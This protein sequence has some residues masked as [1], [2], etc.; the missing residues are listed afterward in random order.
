MLN[1]KLISISAMVMLLTSFFTV[2]AQ[3]TTQQPS[4]RRW[5]W[6]SGTPRFDNEAYLRKYKGMKPDTGNPWTII[7]SDDYLGVEYPQDFDLI[8]EGVH[9]RI[10]VGLND[11]ITLTNGTVVSDYQDDEGNFHFFYPWTDTGVSDPA[12][13]H[14]P[15]YHD[16]ISMERLSYMLQQFD[17]V[18]YPTDTTY[19][20]MP[21][22]RPPGNTKIDILIFNIRDE[23]FWSPE[24]APYY[25]GGYFS[26]AVSLINKRNIIHVDT[27]IGPLSYPYETVVAHEFQ[28]LIHF[29][30]DSDEEL[31]VDEGCADFAIFLCGYGHPADHI[32]YYLVYH[33]LTS[34]TFWGGGLEDY[35]ASYLFILYLSEHYGGAEMI[36]DLVE[37]SLNG[38]EG[39]ENTLA[40]HGYTI[41]FDGVF[42]NWAI[43]NYID[44][45]SIGNGEYG[46]FTLDIPS[47]DTRGLSIE[48]A[49]YNLWQVP[50]IGRGFGLSASVW[51]GFV[52]P[53]TA[54]Y[55]RFG[56][57]PAGYEANLLY[58][59]DAESGT[60]ANDWKGTVIDVTGYA[61]YRRTFTGRK[62]NFKPVM[63]YNVWHIMSGSLT[64]PKEHVNRGHLFVAIF[65]N[66]APHLLPG[67][68][69]FYAY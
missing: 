43:A 30:V 19:F 50:E 3:A 17:E 13:Y 68:Y 14:P 54:N 69:W 58:E 48:Y 28:H 27:Y 67:D 21:E 47:P 44:E 57:K 56:F 1:R 59:G 34:L 10:W 8:L 39:I 9:G 49:L 52:R 5:C 46:Y 2:P 32:A 4:L 37:N 16:V 33:P 55:W 66:A 42:Q 15:G 38:I 11:S 7:V 29:D 36:S 18:I 45:I 35:G 20:G 53:Y 60:L 62:V 61:A 23:V 63:L 51:P 64:I 41:T 12:P 24:T 31:W 25:I 65:W 6:I 26:S 40:T 22:E